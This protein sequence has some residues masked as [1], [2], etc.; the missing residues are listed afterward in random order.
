[1]GHVRGV[2]V[3]QDISDELPSLVTIEGECGVKQN[4]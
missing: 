2:D 4:G 1:M 3:P